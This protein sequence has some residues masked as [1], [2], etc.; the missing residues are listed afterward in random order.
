MF[1]TLFALFI[2]LISAAPAAA[3][4]ADEPQGASPADMRIFEPYI[5]TFKSSTNKFDD[6]KTDYYFTL[7]YHWYDKQKTIVKYTV[8]MVIPSQDRTIV[9]SEGF[10][11]YDAFNERLYV[12]GAFTRGMTG[13]G[14]VG[15]FDHETGARETWAKSKDEQGVTYVRD[16]FTLDGDSGWKNKTYLRIN[17]E[18]EWKVVH[19]DSYTR[20]AS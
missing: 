5:G 20:I 19:E 7:D 12:F 10:Y 4:E 15:R 2:L 16:T 14:S 9:N 18:T 11:G 13:W 3:L 8:S 17:D 1:R 6:G